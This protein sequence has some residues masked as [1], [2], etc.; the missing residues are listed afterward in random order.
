MP[1]PILDDQP[2]TADPA[3]ASLVA[4]LDRLAG[5]PCV[6]CATSLCGHA[7]LFSIALGCK[8]APRCLGCLAATLQRDPEELREALAEHLRHRDCYSTA[9]AVACTRE[10]QPLSWQPECLHAIP[11]AEQ[12]VAQAETPTTAEQV[13][14]EWDAGDLGCG[15]LVLGLR[16]RLNALPGGALFRLIA[17]DPAAPHDLPAW[18]RLTGHRLTHADHPVYLIQRKEN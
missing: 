3:A 6:G 2:E 13:A 12:P 8:D 5:Q 7:V 18:C 15:E 14:S 1:I 4:D 11:H 17:R 16:L 10:N 9:W